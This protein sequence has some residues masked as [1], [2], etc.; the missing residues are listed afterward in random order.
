MLVRLNPNLDEGLSNDPKAVNM[1]DTR[2]AILKLITYPNGRI[3]RHKA[4]EIATKR[5]MC[6]ETIIR[7]ANGTTIKPSLWTIQQMAEASKYRIVMIPIDA[8][9]PAGAK[10]IA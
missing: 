4:H 3:N 10:E 2:A 5:M 8:D 1:A 9:L 7:F 6:A